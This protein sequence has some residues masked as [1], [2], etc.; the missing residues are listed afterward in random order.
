[1]AVRIRPINNFEKNKENEIAWDI[2][3]IE[4]QF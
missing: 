1:V 4:S 2:K 3:T